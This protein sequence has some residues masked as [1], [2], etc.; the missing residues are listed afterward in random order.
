MSGVIYMEIKAFF[1]RNWRYF[2]FAALSTAILWA[3][4][5]WLITLSP[6]LLGLLLAYFFLPIV[7][8]IERILP[9]KGKWLEAK[10]IFAILFI[11]TIVIGV[12]GLTVFIFITT[13][14][15]SSAD[16]FN[17]TAEI[18]QNIISRM[19]QWTQ[20]ILKWLPPDI[21]AQADAAVNN[22]GS[23][24]ANALAGLLSFGRSLA[25][26]ILGSLGFIL[27]FAAIPLFLFYL[28]KDS[29]K[30]QRNIYAELPSIA[31]RHTRNVIQIIERV[32]GR[33]L[34]GA[35]ILGTAVGSLS[36][37]GLLIIGVPFAVPLAVFNGFCEIIPTIGPIVGGTVMALVTLAL[38]PDKVIWIVLMAF[39][40]QLLENNLLV[41]RIQASSLKLHPSLV[42]LLLVLG[43]YLWG[44]WGLLLTVPLTA[45]L[46]GIFTYVRGVNREA[47]APA[48]P[49][50]S[51]ANLLDE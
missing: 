13:L 41:P 18:I 45:T 2:L 39:A 35:L 51:S 5:T 44:L 46:V 4:Y 20:S 48:P 22:L 19:Q 8:F 14:A 26:Q 16:L 24:L 23:S 11:F 30:I 37:I 40:V 1:E 15:H 3:L 28:L 50:A 34:R 42:I 25:A 17:N 6:F 43:G 31:A 10:R 12:F 9:G 7:K 27:G 29:E 38:A 33:Y 21:R 47:N 36:L 49:Q 32:L